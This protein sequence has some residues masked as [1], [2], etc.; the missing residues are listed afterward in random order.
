M[1]QLP[2]GCKLNYSIWIDV[3]ELTDEMCEWFEMIGGSVT[4]KTE[5]FSGRTYNLRVI[6]E[7]RYGQA[8]PSYYR[9]DGTGHVKINFNG[10]DASTAS[11]FLIKF[12]EYVIKHNMQ[13]YNNLHY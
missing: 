9:Q 7:V 3:T 10:N 11:I 6:K 12:N 4:E 2:P 8:K 13:E 1:I 5:A